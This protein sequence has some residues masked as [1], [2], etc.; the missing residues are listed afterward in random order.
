MLRRF[1]Y[2]KSYPKIS[3]LVSIR[4]VSGAPLTSSSDAGWGD[5]TERSAPLMQLDSK[6]KPKRVPIGGTPVNRPQ[7][8][9]SPRRKN[10]M[11]LPSFIVFLVC[12]W[13]LRGWGKSDLAPIK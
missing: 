10:D 4:A 11:V 2:Y 6:D 1:Q 3:A 5:P 12:A 9:R 7:G 13:T 8:Q